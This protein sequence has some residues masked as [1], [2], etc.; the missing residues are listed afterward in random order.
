MIHPALA[1]NYTD[2]K[3]Q[4]AAY[5]IAG[6]MVERAVDKQ[7]YLERALRALTSPEYVEQAQREFG[8]KPVETLA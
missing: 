4:A 8:W 2:P 3:D 7:V 1:R 5:L 6:L